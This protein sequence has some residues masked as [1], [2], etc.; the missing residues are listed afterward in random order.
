[1]L[2]IN[3]NLSSL[4]A[5]NSLNSS[6]KKL[7]QAVERMTTGY[8]INHAKDNAANY[9][10]SVD[11]S[12]KI[13]AYEVAEENAPMA[14]DMVTTAVDSLDL[15]AD[16]LERIRALSEQYVNGTYGEESLEAIVKENYALKEEI[17]RIFYAAEYNGVKLFDISEYTGTAPFVANL[18]VSGS[19]TINFQIG[20][21][22]DSNSQIGIELGIF[23][24]N[25]NF[26]NL[27]P[28]PIEHPLDAVDKWMSVITQKQT[29]YGAIQNRLESALEEI[30]TQYENLTSSR[31]TL[32][33]TDVA[34]TSSEYIKQQILQQ[35]SSTLLATA[36]QFPSLALQLL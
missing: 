31:S 7:N 25:F 2:S 14:L 1:M 9:S 24:Q 21:N 11:M 8:K 19:Q 17:N 28:T 29:E 27:I 4:V 33:D 12:T 23:I 3:T 10:I 15:I 13:G 6:T 35:A 18:G 34:E 26:S 5:Q 20:I 32:R 36:N 30:S 22:G 16:K